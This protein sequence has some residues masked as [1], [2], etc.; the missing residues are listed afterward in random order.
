M[1]IKKKTQ[2][3]FVTYRH[4]SALQLDESALQLDE[5]ALQLDESL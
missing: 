1:L 3:L 2:S 5:S 4:W